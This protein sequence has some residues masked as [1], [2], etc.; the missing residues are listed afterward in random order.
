M[1]N[2]YVYMSSLDDRIKLRIEL[3]KFVMFRKFIKKYIKLLMEF[4]MRFLYKLIYNICFMLW[5]KL[6]FYGYVFIDTIN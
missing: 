1:S 2:H 6:I 5:S 4:A 3:K